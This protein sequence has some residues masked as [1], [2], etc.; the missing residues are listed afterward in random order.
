MSLLDSIPFPLV[1]PEMVSET[2]LFSRQIHASQE[3]LSPLNLAFSGVSGKR[4][5][6]VFLPLILFILVHIPR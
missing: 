6:Y 2:L 4:A 5:N 1:T 3:G